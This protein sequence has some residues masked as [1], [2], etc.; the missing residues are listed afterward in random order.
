MKIYYLLSGNDKEKGFYDSVIKYFQK[1][2]KDNSTITFIASS[3]NNYE[4]ND[5]YYNNMIKFFNDINIKF[6]EIYLID[7][8]ITKEE[9]KELIKSSD[10][11]YI[12]G[13]DP[14]SE[15]ESINSYNLIEVLKKFEGII[16]GVSAG[17]INMNTNI[18]YVDENNNIKEYKGIGLTDY[19]IAPHLDFNNIDYL[20][21]IFRVSKIIKTIALPNESFIR[22]ENGIPEVIGD[23]YIVENETINIE[24]AD[25]TS[26]NH[27]GTVELETERLMLRRTTMED[28]DEF[29]YMQLN[30]KLR[31][32]LGTTKIGNNPEKNKKYFSEDKYNEPDYYRWTIER[33]EDNKLIGTIYLNIHSEKAR[34]AG[35]DYWIREDEWGKG[36]TTEASKKIL[37]YAFDTLNINRIESCGSKNNTG[38]WRVME[39]IGLKYEGT[40][41]DGIFYYYG[42]L[43][44]LVMYGLT[45]EE[46]VD[47][48]KKEWNFKNI[49][50]Y[51]DK[52]HKIKV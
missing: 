15:M 34:T 46:Y 9:A 50:T 27:T 37:E 25:S 1:D 7:T 28:F 43:D 16:I 31:K 41:K 2:I 36:Y 17:S 24:G 23:S 21:E 42:G 48:I 3:F 18:C 33:K 26:I 40:R 32:Y 13:G 47:K 51:Q 22:V 49:L 6:K 4:K 38:T 20:K 39:K 19:N 45:K 12:M 29:F 35:I 8:R 10:I 52:N 30:P 5:L 14:Y 44:D 11:V